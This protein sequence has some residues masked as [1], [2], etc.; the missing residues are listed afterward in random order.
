MCNLELLCLILD[1]SSLRFVQLLASASLPDCT[2]YTSLSQ[3]PSMTLSGKHFLS[4]FPEIILLVCDLHCSNCCSK[5][6]TF[7][8]K[9]IIYFRRSTLIAAMDLAL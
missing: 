8:F 4:R 9:G 2:S 5:Q 7:L 3:V 1:N 6:D